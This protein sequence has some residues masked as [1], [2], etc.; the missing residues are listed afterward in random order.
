MRR[1]REQEEERAERKREKEE[2]EE[3]DNI[4]VI[5]NYTMLLQYHLTNKMVL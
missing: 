5:Y 4:I 1:I 3:R 2:R